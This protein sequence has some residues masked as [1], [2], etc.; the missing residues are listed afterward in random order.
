MPAPLEQVNS[1]VLTL[2]IETKGKTLQEI[3]NSKRAREL[4]EKLDE[5]IYFSMKEQ[6]FN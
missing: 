6:G 2:G 4:K 1:T 3:V 5:C